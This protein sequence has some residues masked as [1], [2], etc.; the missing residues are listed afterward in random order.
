MT[1][2]VLVGST[3]CHNGQKLSR[4]KVQLNKNNWLCESPHYP[5]N[6]T[7][8]HD[9]LECL[10]SFWVNTEF[11]ESLQTNK[12]PETRGVRLGPSSQKLGSISASLSISMCMKN[13]KGLFFCRFY[14]C[15]IKSARDVLYYSVGLH[16]KCGRE[17]LSTSTKPW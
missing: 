6:P 1:F 15:V 5:P 16:E 14:L 13:N 9:C 12:S 2:G 7:V 10:E 11:C 17:M 4:G 3:V 8:W